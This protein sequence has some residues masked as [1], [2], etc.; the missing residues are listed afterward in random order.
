MRIEVFD[1]AGRCVGLLSEGLRAA[2]AHE[3]RWDAGASARARLP[4][5]VY[6]LRVTAGEEV[7]TLRV[8]LV[9]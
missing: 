9:D 5:G 4:G 8:C 7:R 2:G 3:S 1:S 6:A